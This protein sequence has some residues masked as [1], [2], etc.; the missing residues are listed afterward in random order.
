MNTRF[1]ECS[2]CKGDF[3][4]LIT[5]G[6]IDLCL[7]CCTMRFKH[8]TT[9]LRRIIGLWSRDQGIGMPGLLRPDSC[10][11]RKPISKRVTVRR[12]GKRGARRI[13]ILPTCRTTDWRF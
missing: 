10:V 13:P 12:T 7:R 11:R 5:V 1:V 4:I 8:H 6:T 2:E 9:L 3:L